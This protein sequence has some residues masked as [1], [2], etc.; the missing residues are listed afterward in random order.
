MCQDIDINFVLEIR[1]TVK[2]N[3]FYCIRCS[4][5]PG[6]LSRSRALQPN[7]ERHAIAMNITQSIH[8]SSQY[9]VCAFAVL[10]TTAITLAS[11]VIT[12][13]ALV[14]AG[15]TPTSLS[16]GLA[17]AIPIVTSLPAIYFLMRAVY[18]LQQ[19]HRHLVEL[20]Y[21]DELTALAN[22]RNFFVQG[23]RLL[24][25]GQASRQTAALLLLD[26]N[27]FKPIND[28]WGHAAGDDALRA[29]AKALTTFAQADDVVARLGG[30]EFALL[31]RNTTR[32]ELA[33]LA[34]QVRQQ[35]SQAPCEYNGA[36][37]P[38]TISIGMSDTTQAAS[39]EALLHIS[40]MALY[41]AKEEHH[42][43]TTI[44]SESSNPKHAHCQ[45]CP[46]V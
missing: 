46:T 22:R 33:L 35:L 4:A 42:R 17:L 21:T 3:E 20:A 1:Y 38:L 15:A 40:D 16:Y 41:A 36:V 32:H 6:G 23:R 34:A 31:R 25:I 8:I 11:L 45:L 28:T 7:D 13:M 18:Q 24:K 37:L 43:Q 9:R 19:T 44:P 12:H 39:I 26:V 27:N 5:T 29:I 14:L 2:K 30:D 10:I